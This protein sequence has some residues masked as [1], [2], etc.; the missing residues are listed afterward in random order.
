[1]PV[2]TSCRNPASE[3]GGDTVV[4]LSFKIDDTANGVYETSDSLMWKGSFSYNDASGI[5]TFDAF[6][7]GPKVPLYDDGTHGDVTAGDKL[8]SA[9][10]LVVSPNDVD[11][12]LEYGATK[13]LDDWI[14][15]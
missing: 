7:S 10:V 13:G 3:S 12:V 14:W 8:W 5:L 6:W 2:L 11:L 15:T 9:T 1:M 4:E